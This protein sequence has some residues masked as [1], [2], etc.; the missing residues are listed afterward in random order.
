MLHLPGIG[1]YRIWGGTELG[2]GAATDDFFE[3]ASRVS[4]PQNKNRTS[5]GVKGRK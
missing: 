2:T 3:L 4:R 5:S 1:P